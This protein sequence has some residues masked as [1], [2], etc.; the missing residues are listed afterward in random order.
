M[1]VIGPELRA[2]ALTLETLDWAASVLTKTPQRHE[3]VARV[4]RDEAQR[5]RDLIAH[6]LVETPR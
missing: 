2:Q 4:C 6:G 1:T 3:D 5:A